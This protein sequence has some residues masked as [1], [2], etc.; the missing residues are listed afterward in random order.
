MIFE[1]VERLKTGQL[2]ECRD[3]VTIKD[4]GTMI[5]NLISSS[6]SYTVTLFPRNGRNLAFFSKLTV[7]PVFLRHLCTFCKEKMLYSDQLSGL[8]SS[9]VPIYYQIAAQRLFNDNALVKGM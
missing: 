5:L 2:C 4:K 6:C 1:Q 9:E 8:A 7:F 3:H